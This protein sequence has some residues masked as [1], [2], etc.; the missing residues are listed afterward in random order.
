ME[1]KSFKSFLSRI[2]LNIFTIARKV[3][4]NNIG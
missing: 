2:R 1:V 3:S 4:D